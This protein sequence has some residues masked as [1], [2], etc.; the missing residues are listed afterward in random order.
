MKNVLK[1]VIAIACVISCITTQAFAA[2]FKS[3]TVKSGVG[4]SVNEVNGWSA[5]EGTFAK[6][7]NSENNMVCKLENGSLSKTF[8]EQ[9]SGT[10]FVSADVYISEL[11]DN[12][13]TM[14]VNNSESTIAQVTFGNGTLTFGSKEITYLKDTWQ[15]IGFLIKTEEN[16]AELYIDRVKKETVD[17]TVTAANTVSFCGSAYIDNFAVDTL[18]EALT[19]SPD[20]S[21]WKTTVFNDDFTTYTEDTKTIIAGTS[22][23]SGTQVT[24]HNWYVAATTSGKNANGIYA[25]LRADSD[26]TNSYAY[27]AGVKSTTTEPS[28]KHMKIHQNNTNN[29]D[30]NMVYKCITGEDGKLAK[31]ADKA[32]YRIKLNN[33]NAKNTY[34]IDLRGAKADKTEPSQEADP[35]NVLARVQMYWDGSSETG[36]LSAKYFDETENTEKTTEFKADVNTFITGTKA[37]SQ[38]IA[39][40]WMEIAIVTNPETRTYDVY[41]C[42]HD[43][44]NDQSGTFHAG[45]E[46]W[47]KLNEEAIPYYY[48]STNENSTDNVSYFAIY[49]ADAT[50]QAGRIYVESVAMQADQILSKNSFTSVLADGFSG[51]NIAIYKSVTAK[52]EDN[53]K[54]TL[55]VN[56]NTAK[57]VTATAYVAIKSGGEL[58][59]AEPIDISAGGEFTAN[60]ITAKETDELFVYIWN[61]EFVPLT[62]V[63]TAES[64]AE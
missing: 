15:N 57:E 47:K 14:S 35:G 43:F 9:A 63:V 39:K 58:K 1:K 3:Q 32:V 22:E 36:T 24:S 13:L 2:E 38:T 4:D 45:S 55:N 61:D 10:Y 64:A 6:D 53:G 31:F 26:D 23:K 34:Y 5:Q 28:K 42:S 37:P 50:H 44:Y 59:A 18:R 19:D 41:K 27:T 46:S 25:Q 62:S 30:K 56:K 20:A 60:S 12:A 17:I 29:T 49:G 40:A 7:P 51:G 33:Y 16:K 8:S 52:I 21:D 11:K 54:V 48:A